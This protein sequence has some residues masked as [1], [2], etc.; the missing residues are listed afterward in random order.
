MSGLMDGLSS[1][2]MLICYG[3]MLLIVLLVINSIVKRGL[4]FK[5]IL[6]G[7]LLCIFFFGGNIINLN[8]MSSETIAKVEKVKEILND[9]Y[10]EYVKTEGNSVYVC[11][12]D[13]WVNLDEVEIVGN[14]SK[15]NIIT[16]DG[17]EIYLGHSGVYNVIKV[18]GD[19]G[20][21]KGEEE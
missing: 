4:L 7:S 17:E 16:Y 3:V 19:V 14:F 8:F 10:G 11:I 5:L 9:N 21:L 2:Q 6:I 20:L 12:N 1:E 13:N 18:L 15:D